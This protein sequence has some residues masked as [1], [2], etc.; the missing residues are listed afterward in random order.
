MRKALLS[1][2]LLCAV[3]VAAGSAAATTVTVTLSGTYFTVYTK[4]SGTGPRCDPNPDNPSEC[5]VFQLAGFGPADY[6]Y[7]YG[8]LFEP[9]G[10]K[11]CWNEDGRLTITLRSDQSTI[12]GALVGV[13]CVPGGSAY[14]GWPHTYGN[15]YS[16]HLNV[17]FSADGATGQFSGL[18]GTGVFEQSAAGAAYSGTIKAT[19]Q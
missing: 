6:V 10:T 7:N 2:A 11:G 3:A 4:A 15:P 17:Q 16:E 19:L 14:R 9:N 1:L 12:N 8:K 13:F 5:G 18:A